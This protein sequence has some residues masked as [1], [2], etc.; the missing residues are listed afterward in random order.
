MCKQLPTNTADVAYGAAGDIVSQLTHQLG[1]HA[2]LPPLPPS[3]APPKTCPC[4]PLP[5]D[6]S[7]PLARFPLLPPHAFSSPLNKYKCMQE[8]TYT[9]QS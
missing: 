3:P 9:I 5:L 4:P 7:L 1:W 8:D 2:P 6:P